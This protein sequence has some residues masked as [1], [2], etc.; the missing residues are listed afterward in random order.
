M[1]AF[2]PN[3]LGLQNMAGNVWD[4]CADVWSTEHAAASEPDPSGPPTGAPG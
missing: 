2:A 1:D 4:W 3:A